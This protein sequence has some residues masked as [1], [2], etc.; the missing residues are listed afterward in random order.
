MANDDVA[1]LQALVATLQK[2]KDDLLAENNSLRG[3]LPPEPLAL[4]DQ[5]L[6]EVV[7]QAIFT[8]DDQWLP[9]G[10]Q[11]RDKFATMIPN[12]CMMPLNSAA[13]RRYREWEDSLPLRGEQPPLEHV[14]QAAME[15]RPRAGDPEIGHI[16]FQTAVLRRALE[17]RGAAPRRRPVSIQPFRGTD[18][19]L[20][21]NVRIN[22]A[23]RA[24][25]QR[26]AQVVRGPV[27]PA[28]MEQPPVGSRSD[29]LGL[30]GAQLYAGSAV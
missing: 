15:L 9:P 10:V 27:M 7:N 20:M 16:E 11:F 4:D 21:S 19:P 3:E 30:Y 8:Q 14:L 18:A 25:V 13:Q 22:G 1:K 28:N 26:A 17:L 23:P 5:P 2:Q 24:A 6:Y 12:E 29:L